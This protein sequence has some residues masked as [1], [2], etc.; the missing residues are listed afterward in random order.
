MNARILFLAAAAM[1]SVACGPSYDRTDIVGRV[2]TEEGNEISNTHVTVVEGTILKAH[3]ES[4]NSD[5]EKMN[6][7]LE[8]GDPNVMEVDYV[9]SDHDFT[10]QG[11]KPGD[12]QITIKANGETVL[13]IQAHVVQQPDAPK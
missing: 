13:I 12:T 4:F 3:I 8:S 7:L 10:F 2:G 1:A 9:I 5:N 6:N 11:V